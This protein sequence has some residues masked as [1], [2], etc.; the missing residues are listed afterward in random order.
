M[1]KSSSSSKLFA[2]SQ[3]LGKH[4][5]MLYKILLTMKKSVVFDVAVIRTG[6]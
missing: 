5:V 4:V 2:I 3:E 1:R 6:R